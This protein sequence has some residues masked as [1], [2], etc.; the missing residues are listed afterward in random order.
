M[1]TLY[2]DER[3]REVLEELQ[4]IYP[5]LSKND[6]ARLAIYRFYLAVKAA[7]EGRDPCRELLPV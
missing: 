1:Y 4:Q 3:F 7:K 2:L 5:K 6:I